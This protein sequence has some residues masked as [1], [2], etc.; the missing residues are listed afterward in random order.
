[1]LLADL[2]PA[3]LLGPLFGAACDRWSRRRCVVVADVLRAIAFVGIAMVDSFAAM[4]AFAALA[5]IG[6]AIYGPAVL[7]GLPSLVS[8]RRLPAATSI[9]GTLDELGWTVGP[10][11]AAGVLI[12]ATPE[13]LTIANGL[14]FAVSAVLLARLP[15]GAKPAAKQSGR[16]KSPSL[17]REAG[18]GLRALADMPAIRTIMLTSSGL[19]MFAGGLN[20]GELFLATDELGAGRSG[21]AVLLAVF[22][23]GVAAGSLAGSR[24]GVP[25]ALKAR[26]LWGM[27]LAGFAFLAS[28]L[29]PSYPVAVVAFT[30]GGVGNGLVIVHERLLLQTTVP[31]GLMGRV[32]GIRDTLQ[33]WGFAPGFLGAGALAVLVGPRVLFVVAGAGALLMWL[34]AAIALRHAWNDQAVDIPARALRPALV[35]A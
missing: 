21:Y 20:V 10:L 9:Y 2:V 13:S 22:G 12:F 23:L 7:A 16:E 6:T 28:G 31:D 34:V 1:M 4:V 3:M 29:A 15:F 24:G 18:D 19:L 8:E 35:E 27:L 5:G 17:I 32:F 25:S 14:T 30:L 33:C 26:Y 11:L